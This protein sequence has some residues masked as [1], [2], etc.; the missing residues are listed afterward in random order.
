[1]KK[2]AMALTVVM[3]IAAAV[4]S[5]SMA[6]SETSSFKDTEKHWSKSYVERLYKEGYVK[7]SD[8]YFKPDGI[9]KTEDFI[10]MAIKVIKPEYRDLT[11]GTG[12]P[13]YKPYFDKAK[14]IG[15]MKEADYD[16]LPQYEGRTM[17]RELAVQVV[18]RALA[19]MGEQVAADHGLE[20][21][22][23]DY[24]IIN[25][26]NK[27]AVLK[28]YQLGIIKG[29][30]GSFHPKDPLTRAEAAVLITKLMDKSMRDKMTFSK[31]TKDYGEV[32]N[33]F[34]NGFLSQIQ[35]RTV[36]IE[37]KANGVINTGDVD[38]TEKPIK[39]GGKLTNWWTDQ[40][41]E[42]DTTGRGTE[43]FEPYSKQVAMPPEI[44]NK[45]LKDVGG[46][47]MPYNGQ[48]FYI[49]IAEKHDG[50]VSRYDLMDKNIKN[51]NRIAYDLTKYGTQYAKLNDLYLQEFIDPDS[52][53]LICLSQ[54]DFSS[55]YKKGYFAFNKN[56]ANFREDD[57]PFDPVVE[58]S[59]EDG[60]VAKQY[61][62]VFNQWFIR[63]YGANDG[64]AIYKMYL[65]YSKGK[66]RGSKSKS[67]VKTYNGYQLRFS[68][69][70]GVSPCL[71]STMK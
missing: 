68:D 52:H 38:Y 67:M 61:A 20:Y 12:E 5:V 29:S 2:T 34:L 56:P 42:D 11:A 39:M 10:I 49:N 33:Y 28:A 22:F 51:F 25:D 70:E 44:D 64:P 69:G 24:K 55:E 6:V 53:V 58:F 15:L 23:N 9:L 21:K 27:E 14:E 26:T 35:Q 3:S 30:N 17:P 57:C 60:A 36:V 13:Y 41:F 59:A 19:L 31:N 40:E 47:Y 48:L 50:K 65:D 32:I 8:G 7:G 18:D 63:V 45:T 4:P 1:M 54:N 71:E 62:D 37:K 43:Y 66:D 46:S 16:E